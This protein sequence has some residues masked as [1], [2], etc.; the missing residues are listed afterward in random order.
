MLPWVTSLY[1]D[2]Q[3]MFHLTSSSE[4]INRAIPQMRTAVIG[5]AFTSPLVDSGTI[6]HKRL[7]CKDIGPQIA[8]KK[9]SL[10]GLIN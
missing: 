10:I 4:Y 1:V 6:F 3:N 5:R 9:S 8:I 2:S 7:L